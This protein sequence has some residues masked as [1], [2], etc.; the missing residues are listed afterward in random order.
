MQI[1]Y[2]LPSQ[3][4]FCFHIHMDILPV[5]TNILRSLF[6]CSW[7]AIVLPR[8]GRNSEVQRLQELR[9]SL[10]N[11]LEAGM[12]DSSSDSDARH[13]NPYISA[14]PSRACMWE[15]HADPFA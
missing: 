3:W 14:A 7:P 8:G 10:R 13:V 12:V 15:L 5:K 9:A 2:E 11:I 1:L 6:G 4:P